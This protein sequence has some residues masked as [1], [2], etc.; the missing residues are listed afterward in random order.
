M[1][2][3]EICFR[4]RISCC[5]FEGGR[6]KFE[7]CWKKR[8]VRTF[9][10]YVQIRGGVGEISIPTVEA[11]PTIKPPEYIWWPSTSRLLGAV[12][13]K[14]KK[15]YRKN[16][17]SSRLTLGGLITCA[18][19]QWLKC[20]RMQGNAVP[21]LKLKAQSVP[22]LQIVTMLGKAHGHWEGPEPECTVLPPL[23]C[24]VTTAF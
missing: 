20:N 5:I 6:F 22:P 4:V 13:K 10:P 9:W 3:Q 8:Q 24:T 15:V 17:R 14:E 19:Q 12:Y 18:F 7:W 1:T 2:T 21:H 16:L 11:L 23:I